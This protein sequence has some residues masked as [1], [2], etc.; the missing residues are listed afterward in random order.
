VIFV[1]KRVSLKIGKLGV[2]KF[3][4]GWY[5]YTGSA[6]GSGSTGLF[7][8]IYRHLKKEKKC[9]WHIDYLL[10]N[11]Y[12]SISAIIFA[13]TDKRSECNII[14][15]IFRTSEVEPVSKFGSSDCKK[16]CKSHLYYF[17]DK[18]VGS[19]VI[20]VSNVYFHLGL[21]PNLYIL[22]HKR[23]SIHNKD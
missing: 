20:S 8:R 18:N 3:N 13:I 23:A 4:K 12:S 17:I 5:A 10:R 21:F 9:F 11:N 14:Q 15:E 19:I 1:A 16:R 2:L 22:N 7:E 6:L